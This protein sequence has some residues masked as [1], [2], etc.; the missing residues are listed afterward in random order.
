MVETKKSWFG[1]TRYSAALYLAQSS[2]PWW[3]LGE[4]IYFS[5]RLQSD[6]NIKNIYIYKL[7]FNSLLPVLRQFTTPRV[8][9]SLHLSRT[10]KIPGLKH[11]HWFRGFYTPACREFKA[12]QQWNHKR[13][14]I[15]KCG[16]FPFLAPAVLWISCSK[17]CKE[18][19]QAINNLTELVVFLMFLWK[20]KE[21]GSFT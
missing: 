16:T 18:V 13:S 12:A 19:I 11:Y 21:N 15:S 9:L 8:Y 10:S 4:D 5:C 7:H 14:H 17:C 2:C 3:G 6:F 1:G 20:L